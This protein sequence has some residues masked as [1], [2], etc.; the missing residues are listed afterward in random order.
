MD[1][2]F[3]NRGQSVRIGRGLLLYWPHM[4]LQAGLRSNELCGGRSE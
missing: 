3:G 2:R 4:C 1:V